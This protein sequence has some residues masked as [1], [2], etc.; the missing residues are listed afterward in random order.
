MLKKCLESVNR[1][2]IKV[3]CN[4]SYGIPKRSQIKSDVRHNDCIG[5]LY[6]VIEVSGGK[7]TLPDR[8][9]RL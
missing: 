8:S 4:G 6:R 2:L 1:R 9:G 5:S 7:P 3:T